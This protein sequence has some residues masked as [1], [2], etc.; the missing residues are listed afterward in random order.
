[1]KGKRF[2]AEKKEWENLNKWHERG[3]KKNAMRKGN[4][5]Q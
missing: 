4:E 2:G 3:T 5:K 1:M